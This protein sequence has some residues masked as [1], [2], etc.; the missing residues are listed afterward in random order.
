MPTTIDRPVSYPRDAVLTV[1]AVA[2]WLGKSE[3]RIYALGIKRTPTGHIL[4][5]WVYDWMEANA[6]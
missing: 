1:A 6:A 4:A 5:G 2:L 3:K